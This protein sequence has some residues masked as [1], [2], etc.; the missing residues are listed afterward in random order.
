MVARA[1][2]LCGLDTEL[3]SGAIRDVLAQFTDYVKTAEWARPGLAFCYQTGILDDSALNI[4]GDEAI[5]RCE[6]A[7]MLFQLL[8]SANLL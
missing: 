8:G 2:K 1:A 6:I 3:D 7:Q 4:N 5:R